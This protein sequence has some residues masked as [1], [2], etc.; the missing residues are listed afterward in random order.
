[1]NEENQVKSFWANRGLYITLLIAALVVIAVAIVLSVSMGGD[2]QTLNTSGSNVS[3]KTGG[4]TST[5]GSSQ[6]A[7]NSATANVN[8]STK[9][10]DS[11]G[12]NSGTSNS[13]GQ[14]GN[15]SGG[16]QT[17]STEV[18]FI[19][20]VENGICIKDY[21]EASVV[22]NKTLGMYTGHMG[23]DITGEAGANVLCVY[24]G[25]VTAITTSY[26]YGTTVTVS[27]ANGIKTVYNS[28]EVDENLSVGDKV[29][30]G[31]VLG[32]IS[33]NNRQEYKDGAHLHF[34]VE[35][36]GVKIS[37]TKYFIGYDK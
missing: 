17:I 12:G 24:D 8:Q 26:I 18:R 22:Y 1:M 25:E 32:V 20:P 5:G 36:N 16:E 23:M 6:S 15:S 11:V 10:I 7:N 27:H 2:S 28:I 4:S 31:D 21:T 30:Q 13:A 35:E 19:M 37:P 34:E 29:S 33:E 9:P 3:A 14:A